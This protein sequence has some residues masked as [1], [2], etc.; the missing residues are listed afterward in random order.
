MEPKNYLSNGQAGDSRASPEEAQLFHQPDVLCV[1]E[2]LHVY[3]ARPPE[4]P[5]R[6]LLMALLRD[7]IDCYLRDCF[8][9]NR[10]R[11]SSFREAEEWFFSTDDHGVFSLE[12]VCDVL[13]IDAGY[14]RRSLL[15]Y[16]RKN[17]V[18]V[19]PPAEK[20]HRESASA[21]LRLAS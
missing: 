9:A 20:A 1:D 4:T 15:D 10:H 2:Y 8:T 11:K 14:I 13:D 17:A 18:T 12:N 6:R 7:G 5:E 19:S 3:R 16:Q 21:N